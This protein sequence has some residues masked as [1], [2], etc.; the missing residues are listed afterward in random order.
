MEK[1]QG[2]EE[3]VRA[4]ALEHHNVESIIRFIRDNKLNDEVDFVQGGLLTL[5]VTDEEFRVTMDQYDAA[6]KADVRVDGVEWLTKEQT[7]EVSSHCANVL[8]IS[9][10]YRCSGSVLH[11]PLC[12]H[13]E[14]IYGHSN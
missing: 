7:Q 10:I 1:Q 2:V 5:F 8:V 9:D 12:S 14:T 6:V 4:K 3:A 11:I 13:Q